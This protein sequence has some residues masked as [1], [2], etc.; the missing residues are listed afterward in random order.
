MPTD[1]R[2]NP[3]PAPAPV[4]A[5]AA[6]QQQIMQMALRGPV[7]RHYANG[8]S[9]AMTPS[10]LSV[11]LLTNGSPTGVLSMSYITAKNLIDEL[12]DAVKNFEKATSYKIKSVNEID[13]ELRKIMEGQ[14]V[15]KL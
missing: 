6:R 1:E 7:P 11:V 15:A 12:T 4:S 13:A 8:I 14:N 9:V 5:E 2:P 10:D 3:A